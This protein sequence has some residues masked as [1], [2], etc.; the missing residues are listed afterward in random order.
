MLEGPHWR[1]GSHHPRPERVAQLVKGD[2]MDA[3]TVDRLLEAADEL[4]AIERLPR[5]RVT[6]H[7]VAVARLHRSL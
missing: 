1:S 6:E 3:G 4:R 7:E 5:L 2:P